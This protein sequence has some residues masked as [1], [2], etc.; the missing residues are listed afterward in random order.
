[1]T[2]STTSEI[3]YVECWITE[4]CW[5][6]HEEKDSLRQEMLDAGLDTIEGDMKREGCEDW[7]LLDLREA[8]D[9]ISLFNKVP[10]DGRYLDFENVVDYPFMEKHDDDGVRFLFGIRVKYHS[11]KVH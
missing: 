11:K 5:N 4:E 7:D 1:M 9:R 2:L 8:P 10:Q 6:Q 3:M